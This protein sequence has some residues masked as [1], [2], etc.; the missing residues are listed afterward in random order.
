MLKKLK[1]I[2]GKIVMLFSGRL[3]I[4]N[5]LILVA[6]AV[7]IAILVYVL[8]LD[9]VLSKNVHSLGIFG[10][11]FAGAFYTFGISTP[12]AFLIL[13]EAMELND[14]I[15]IAFVASITAALVD[16]ALFILLKR[17]LEK[18]TLKL[19]K[20]IRTKVGKHN[21]VFTLIGFFLFGSPFPD[22]L[23]LAFMQISEIKPVRIA[24][25]VFLAKFLTLLITYT[26][27]HNT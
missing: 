11:I 10:A 19:I 27:L 5:R 15:L 4:K 14:Y 18:N 20:T 25:I 9:S 8:G 1:L 7:A 17:Q 12:T 24:L 22:E 6:L 21:A 26:V 23:A 2:R 13:L 3:T 16:A